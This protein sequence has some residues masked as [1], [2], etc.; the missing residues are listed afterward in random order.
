MLIGLG[1]LR[2]GLG[3]WEICQVTFTHKKKNQ[4]T[5]LNDNDVVIFIYAYLTHFHTFIWIL[6]ASFLVLQYK[7]ILVLNKKL[8]N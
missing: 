3:L 7:S 4:V 1:W 6:K 2:L 5:S 8:I